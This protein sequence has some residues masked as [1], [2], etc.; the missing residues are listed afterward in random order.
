VEKP[1]RVF[2]DD[3]D[4]SLIEHG[5]M[6]ACQPPWELGPPPQKTARAVQVHVVCTRRLFALATAYR[7][8]CERAAVGDAP[9]GWPRWRR[10]LLEQTREQVIGCVPGY[11]GIFPL[12]EYSLL[13]GGKLNDVPPGIGSR[14][15]ILAKYPLTR[16]S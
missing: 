11:D 14:Q 10:Q 13:L 6:K 16:R 4:R 12:A 7:L 9:V 3:D 1:W 5:W 2:D 15:E 8:P